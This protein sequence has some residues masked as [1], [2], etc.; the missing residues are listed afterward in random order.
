MLT[1]AML[2]A[3]GN[4]T[5]GNN[6]DNSDDGDDNDDD[7]NNGDDSGDGDG[8][9]SRL[10]ASGLFVIFVANTETELLWRCF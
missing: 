6:N 10:R 8:D 2:L 3:T 7:N 9:G 5:N 1:T 4:N